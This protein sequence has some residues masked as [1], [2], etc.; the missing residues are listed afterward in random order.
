MVKYPDGKRIALYTAVGR[1]LQRRRE[2]AGITLADLAKRTGASTSQLSNAENG[3]PCPLWM[4]VAIAEAY[5]V[6]LD[7][8]VP[9]VIAER[10]A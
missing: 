6:T 5:D 8:L 7:D 1:E 10:A 3:G 9:V 4:L 2:A